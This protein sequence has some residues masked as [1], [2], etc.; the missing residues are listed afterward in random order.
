MNW[1][2]RLF[3]KAEQ[4]VKYLVVELEKATKLPELTGDLKESLKTLV[5]H[6][7]FVYL[8][9]KLRYERALLQKYLSE[10][11]Q[12]DEKALRH[13][14]AGVHYLGYLESEIKRLT[15]QTGAAARES[16]AAEAEAFDKIRASVDLIGQ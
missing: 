16:F 3:G 7:G 11:Y 15:A 2:K 4:D 10:G 5:F 12:L 9:Q 13:L 8:Q 1:L 14:Q 6:P